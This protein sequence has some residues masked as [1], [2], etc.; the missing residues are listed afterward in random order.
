MIKVDSIIHYLP[1]VP[2]SGCRT[3]AWIGSPKHLFLH[4]YWG[5][6]QSVPRPAQTVFPACPGSS[7]GV[8]SQLDKTKHFLREM[9]RGLPNQVPKPPQHT[10]LD[11]EELYFK[12]LQDNWPSQPICKGEPSYPVE[13]PLFDQ[14]C[15][16][17]FCPSLAKDCVVG[18]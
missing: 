7:P 6:I 3:A 16:L 14:L 1:L 10:L 12:F 8:S 9:S 17:S 15:S 5:G 2:E 11:V 18:M 4:L 13:T